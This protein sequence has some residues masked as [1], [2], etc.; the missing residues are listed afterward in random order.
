MF[1]ASTVG[2]AATL[3]AYVSKAQPFNCQI[4]VPPNPLTAQ[5]LATPY[6]MSG[7]NQ[8]DFAN[9]GSFVEAA[10]LNPAT[11]AISIYSPLVINNGMQ[12]GNG[13]IAPVV[14]TLPAN[15]VV[16]IWFGS[17]AQT[18]TLTG[19]TTGCVNGLGGSIFG[20]FAYCNA[21]TFFTA[22][23]TAISAG[24]LKVPP[25]GT[26]TKANRQACPSTR[27]FRV[28][29]MDQSD[30]VDT[31]YLLIN[32]KLLAQNTATNAA[33]SK[34]ATVLS[35]GSDNALINSFIS[36]AMGCTPYT[37]PS[38]TTPTGTSGGLALNELQANQSPPVPPALVPMND[39]FTVI[40][41]NNGAVTQ[42]LAKT[43]LYRAGVGQPQAA[44]A[45]DASGT[46]Y[47][48]QYAASA[49]FI[50]QNQALF[51]GTT[52]PAPAVANNLF[53]FLANRF[54]TSFGPV[55]SLGCSTIFNVNITSLVQQTM[56]GNCVVVAAKI[57]TAP[58]QQILNG[59]IKPGGAGAVSS[60][61]SKTHA[62]NV[63]SAAVVATGTGTGAGRHH[64]WLGLKN[65]NVWARAS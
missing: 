29:D 32:G 13:F 47:C 14:P 7:C 4:E 50:A 17:N 12:V 40:A 64:H 48:Q 30:N 56:N 25:V 63:A 26:S 59:Q 49:L 3:F 9:Q 20:Q 19:S 31:T 61:T 5:G 21:P 42:S 39:D 18:V 38:I 11:G 35:N 23:Q 53:T 41:G 1:S 46:T 8:L 60:A 58:F 6:K 51:T 15:A 24:L 52:S 33:S 28:V 27:D 16:G 43:N 57:N 54:A 10:I 36:P 62:A 65:R 22:A 2:V 44:T 34:N 37:A 55:P 45:A